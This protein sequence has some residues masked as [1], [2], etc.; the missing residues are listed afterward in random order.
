MAVIK[1]IADRQEHML[2]I[3]NELADKAIFSAR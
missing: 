2:E 3:M 1:Q